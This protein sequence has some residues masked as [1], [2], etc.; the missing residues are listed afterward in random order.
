MIKG[1]DLQ[2]RVGAP[3]PDEAI[4]KPKDDAKEQLVSLQARI[5]RAR[6]TRDG[7]ERHCADCFRRGRDAALKI[8][9]V[10]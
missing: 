10:A 1:S 9:D 7:E 6:V 5:E 4:A 3:E 8:I 2:N